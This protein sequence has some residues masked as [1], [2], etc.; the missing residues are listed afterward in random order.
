MIYNLD[1]CP[2]VQGVY[3]INFPNGK[4]YIGISNNILR[5]IHEHNNDKRQTILYNAIQ[6]YGK[7]YEFE[8]L[9]ILMEASRELLLQREEYWILYY[10]T[11]DRN[12]GYNLTPGGNGYMSFYNPNAKFNYSD[13]EEIKWL[14]INSSYSE[15]KIAQIFNC[16]E[17]A[18]QRI[19][20]G[21]TYYNP[22]WD[23]PIRKNKT[24]QAGEK[25]HNAYFSNKDIENIYQDLQDMNLSCSVI[26]KKH[27]CA[28][29]TISAIN[30]GI[31][32]KQKNWQYP[33]RTKRVKRT[34][35]D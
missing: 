13:L 28:L 32:Y 34:C 17:A 30:R 21:K 14:L 26:A 10:H 35:I 25:N 4:S 12:N 11:D 7:I 3:K 18:I 19:N 24:S 5:R 8:V 22:Q 1:N 16:S 23:Y 27:N 6:K 33:I 9:E 29:S 2:I 31:S 15:K 20:C